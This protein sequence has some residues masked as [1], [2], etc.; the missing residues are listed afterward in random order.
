VQSE[1]GLTNGAQAEDGQSES[2]STD[3]ATE[4]YVLNTNTGKFHHDWCKSVDQMKDKN[5]QVVEAT[6][7]EVIAK[8]YDP[9]KNC[10]P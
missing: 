4:T 9:C 6:R 10:N 2:Q 3:A 7:D 5:K 1:N 8:G